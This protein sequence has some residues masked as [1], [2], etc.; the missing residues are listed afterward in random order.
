MKE[1][2]FK[3]PLNITIEHHITMTKTILFAIAAALPMMAQETAPV[4]APAPMAPQGGLAAQ[5]PEGK[6]CMKGQRHE[7]K[8]CMKGQHHEGKP[9]MQGPRPEGKP[10]PAPAPKA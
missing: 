6:P 9:G 5:R 4:P 3:H 8:P 10:A 2:R 1:G 7:G